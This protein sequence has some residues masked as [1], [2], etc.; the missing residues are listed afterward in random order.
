MYQNAGKTM[1]VAREDGGIWGDSRALLLTICAI[2]DFIL[3]PARFW[4]CYAEQHLI[5]DKSDREI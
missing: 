1:G 5:N 4:D 2:S 3:K